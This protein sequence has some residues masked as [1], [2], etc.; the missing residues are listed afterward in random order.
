MMKPIK[1]YLITNQEEMLDLVNGDAIQSWRNKYF[2]N[3]DF[4]QWEIETM[5]L[6]FADHPMQ[7][8]INV[9][10]FDDLPIEPEIATIYRTKTGRN[11]PMYRLTMI[12]GIVVAKDKLHSS[13]TLLTP[14]G[15]VEVKFRKEQFAHYDAQISQQ[16]NGKKQVVERSWL[17]RGNGLII[18][19]MRQDDLFMAKVYRNS[20]MQHTA[21]K[22][23]KI[24]DTGKIEV[25][26]ERKKG[27]EEDSGDDDE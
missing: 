21:F 4:A 13:I 2:P 16:V 20:P 22:I 19:G 18:H 8:V 5:G 9:S 1:Q 3:N 17:N 11:V 14:E 7:N 10:N 26:K 6:C 27:F 15:P 24:L 25:Q 23:T 12:C